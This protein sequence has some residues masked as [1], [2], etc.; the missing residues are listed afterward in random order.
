MAGEGRPSTSF[1]DAGSEDV[2]GR[3]KP[4]HDGD[5]RATAG[6]DSLVS[7]WDL[8][9]SVLL[10]R[11]D[12]HYSFGVLRGVIVVQEMPIASDP[13][14]PETRSFRRCQPGPFGTTGAERHP[15]GVPVDDALFNRIGANCFGHPVSISGSLRWQPTP[16]SQQ[17]DS[18]IV[19]R[20][21]IKKP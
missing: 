7:R 9:R 5:T 15:G 19:G 10:F 1:L 16:D 8:P 11:S 2:D 3:A 12:Q 18:S 14:L 6:T 4:G 13:Q 21:G 17:A 20:F